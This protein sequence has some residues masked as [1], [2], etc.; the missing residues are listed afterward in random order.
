MEIA[1]SEEFKELLR[2]IEERIDLVEKDIAPS[3]RNKELHDV[4]YKVGI[5]DGWVQAR[6]FL[7]G[8]SGRKDKP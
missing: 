3:A 1:R 4:R 2:Q 8:L 5:Y 6:Q 7:G